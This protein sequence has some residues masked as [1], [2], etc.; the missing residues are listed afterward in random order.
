[1]KKGLPINQIICGD[2]L[3]VMK[4]WPDGH[5]D[6]VITDPPY[7]IGASQGF[8][9]SLRLSKTIV[10][11]EWDNKIPSKEYFEEILRLS[12]NQIIWGGNY[13]ADYLYA[14]RCFL[15]WDKKNAGRDFA[16]CE[17]AWTSFDKVARIFV[18]RVADEHKT[19]IH[20][21]QKALA[22]MVWCVENYSN[23]DNLILDPF[24]GSGTTCV[25]AKMLGRDYIGI[26]ISEKYCEISRDRLNRV[27]RG[28]KLGLF[29]KKITRKRKKIKG[30]DL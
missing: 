22:L 20:P 7:G 14:T 30:F 9:R 23:K 19:R 16:D 8:G 1:M 26:D 5:A 6:L 28:C 27:S 2:C 11:G 4:D 21:T 10:K 12:S 18:K 15:V 17:V 25:A 24:C 3:E 29:D 13:F